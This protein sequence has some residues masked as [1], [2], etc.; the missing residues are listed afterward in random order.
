MAAPG[1]TKFSSS[2]VEAAAVLKLCQGDLRLALGIIEAQL[3]TLHTRGQVLVTLAGAVVT[4]TGFSGRMIAGTSL[5]AQGLI[6]L[7]LAAVLLGAALTFVGVMQVR[8]ITADLAT[9][10]DTALATAISRRNQ[11]TRA[12]RIGGLLLLGGLVFYFGA[13]GLMLLHP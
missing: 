6:L 5:L 13:V 7:G 1:Q 3:N 10:T 11:K 2:E 8:W 9:N 4:V 12:Y